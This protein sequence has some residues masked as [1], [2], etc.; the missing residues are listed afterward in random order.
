MNGAEKLK[1]DKKEERSRKKL[2]KVTTRVDKEWQSH[3]LK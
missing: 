3:L 1:S 2:E